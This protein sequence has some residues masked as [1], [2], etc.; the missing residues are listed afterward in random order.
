[1][2]PVQD[3]WLFSFD[4]KNLALCVSLCVCVVQKADDREKRQEAHRFHFDAMW[5]NKAASWE[6]ILSRMPLTWPPFPL[7]MFSLR[8]ISRANKWILVYPK[9]F[10]FDIFQSL[11][12]ML[13]IYAPFHLFIPVLEVQELQQGHRDRQ[14][15][16]NGNHSQV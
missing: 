6:T 3:K 11:S 9:T 7:H 12:Q 14:R 15:N 10:L 5:R 1:M 8:L 4:L 16:P 13:N 2:T